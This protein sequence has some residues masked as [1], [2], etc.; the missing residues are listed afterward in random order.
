MNQSHPA[1]EELVD[2]LHGAL[3]AARDA[4]VHAHIGGCLPCTR[5]YEAEASL[6]EL[7]RA[8][9]RAEERELPPSVVASIY[10]AIESRNRV[11]IWERVRSALRP[12]VVVPAAAAA[13]AAVLYFAASSW[14][15][16]S[17]ATAIDA[18]YY[19]NN[20]AALTA[21]TPFA[22]DAPVPAALTSDDTAAEQQPLDASR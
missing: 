20:H 17:G 22:E 10:A 7:L 12:T 5:A 13:C 16:A 11:P 21:S 3:P 18:A 14:H 6:T 8:Q 4:A 15:G 1:I 2:Y 9:A 19:L